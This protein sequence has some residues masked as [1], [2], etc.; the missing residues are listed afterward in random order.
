MESIFETQV[1][2]NSSIY[3]DG[4]LQVYQGWA[5]AL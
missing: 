5:P 1:D 3:A 4:K 2:M